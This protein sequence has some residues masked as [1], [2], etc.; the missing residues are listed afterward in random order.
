M[1]RIIR[2]E[3]T[4]SGS[5]TCPAGVTTILLFGCGGGQS[6][7]GSTNNG[8]QGGAGANK[9]FH[10]LTVVPNTSYTITVG[11]GG[12]GDGGTVNNGTESSFGALASFP[13]PTQ[14]GGYG[15]GSM[16]NTR[17]RQYVGGSG[18]RG[19]AGQANGGFVGGAA[20]NAY[21]GGGAGGYGDGGAG[22]DVGAGVSAAANTGAGGG[23]SGSGNSGSG[24][25]GYIE[26]IWSE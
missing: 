24:G 17:L 7:E 10:V 20:V 4:S 2:E 5:W 19:V 11:A 14:S 21:G 1:A 3:F 8:K 18:G 26:I 15:I 6:G 23:S 16:L 25:S 9:V 12:T 22:N 13:S